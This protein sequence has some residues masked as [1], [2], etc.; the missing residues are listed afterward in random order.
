M[1]VTGQIESGDVRGHVL[2]LIAVLSGD[3]RVFSLIWGTVRRGRRLVLQIR[4][5]FRTRLD[6]RH[7]M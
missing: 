7:G 2:L 3:L 6:G 5:H 1:T 4:V